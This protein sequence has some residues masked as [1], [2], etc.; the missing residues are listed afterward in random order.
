MVDIIVHDTDQFIHQICSGYD[1]ILISIFL[2]VGVLISCTLT[3]EWFRIIIQ[4]IIEWMITYQ[5]IIAVYHSCYTITTRTGSTVSKSKETMFEQKWVMFCKRNGILVRAVSINTRCVMI[6]GCFGS[7]LCSHKIKYKHKIGDV[8]AFVAH[9]VAGLVATSESIIFT[10]YTNDNLLRPSASAR[11]DMQIFGIVMIVSLAV[12]EANLFCV[13]IYFDNFRE[14]LIASNS[15]TNVLSLYSLCI[16]AQEDGNKVK[17]YYQF[18]NNRCF[19]Y[20]S[21]NINCQRKSER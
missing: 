5:L 3:I 18:S 13:L 16:T 10:G 1:V 12:V 9:V 6:I 4:D 2:R 15:N 21:R 7:W 19:C 20:R 14:Y 11:F 17:Q 8:D